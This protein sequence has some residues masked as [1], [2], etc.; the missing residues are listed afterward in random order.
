MLR[1]IVATSGSWFIIPLRLVAG[2]IFIGHGAQKLFG[3]FGGLGLS[4]WTAIPPPFAFMAPQ[5][6]YW[7]IAAAVA[8]FVGGIFVLLG[9]FT[10]VGAFFLLCTMAGAIAATRAGGFFAPDGIE[11]PLAMTGICLALLL[12]GG[13]QASGDMALS[14][15][16]SS[17]K[18]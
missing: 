4:K 1:R 5:A 11:L 10:R 14:Q 16:R 7:M 17:N 9:L 8:E 15:R 13:G 3:V 18:R 6:K 12:A 2:A